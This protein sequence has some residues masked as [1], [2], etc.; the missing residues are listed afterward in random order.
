MTTWTPTRW[1]FSF[2]DENGTLRTLDDI[3]GLTSLPINVNPDGTLTELDNYPLEPDAY[4]DTDGTDH[5]EGD[6]RWKPMAGYSGQ[7]GYSGP[8]M[9][10]SEYI[11]GRMA[12]DILSTPGI[13]TTLVVG[14]YDDD[15]EWS[16]EPAG[17]AVVRIVDEAQE[18]A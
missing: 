9:H 8:V 5:F 2:A 7:H 17:W 6:P 3:M 4:V 1:K 18:D 16:E 12:E 14:A 10:A 13:Y 15:G 11:G